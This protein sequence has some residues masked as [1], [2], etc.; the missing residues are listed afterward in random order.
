MC[1]RMVINAGIEPG[2]H[3]G[4]QDRDYTVVDYVEDWVREDDTIPMGEESK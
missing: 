2:G 3:P 1:R 4:Y